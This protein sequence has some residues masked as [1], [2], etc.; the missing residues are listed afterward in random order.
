MR[1][2]FASLAALGLCACATVPKEPESEV[3]T[4][5][6]IEITLP[7]SP[8]PA[9]VLDVVADVAELAG[10]PSLYITSGARTP[11]KQV[12]VMIEYY[13]E[14]P[15]NPVCGVDYFL[16]T[17]EPECLGNMLG[18]YEPI[19]DLSPER[20]E[21]VLQAM[22]AE[23]AGAI[24]ALDADPNVERDCMGHVEAEGRYAIDIAP[25]LTESRF[26]VYHAVRAMGDRILQHR[27]FYP[28]IP[29]VPESP[30]PDA[31]FHLEVVTDP[32]LPPVCEAGAACY[33]D[34]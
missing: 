29:F 33:P 14:C 12:E 23:V 16:Q 7:S 17:Y 3:V 30:A 10:E 34:S 27:F 20:R 13:L 19:A 25:S 6:G 26:A 8:V 21:A 18:V 24:A 9:V 32:P 4:V 31:A 5:R 2:A 11:R 1:T 28:D 22:T 15:D